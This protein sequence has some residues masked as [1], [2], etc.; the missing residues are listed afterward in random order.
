VTGSRARAAIPALVAHA[1]FA[2]VFALLLAAIGQPIFT[3]DAW[4]HLGLGEAFAAKGPWLDVDPLLFTAPRPPD[5]AAW[6]FDVALFR[7]WEAA[8]YTGLRLIH[9]AAVAAIV[10]LAWAMLRRA[11]GSG[12]A[13]SA[14][15]CAFVALSALRLVQLRPEL[16]TIFGTLALYAGL[17]AAPT[18]PPLAR[19]AVAAV[20]LCL[21]ANVHAG[22]TL[23]LLLLAV[24]SA[25]LYLAA[26]FT[27]APLR[28]ATRVRASRLAWALVLGGALTLLNPEGFHAHVA[29]FE[30]GGDTPE[31]SRVADEWV[32]WQPLRRPVAGLPPSPLAFALAW[33]LL[34]ATP[35]AIGAARRRMRARGGGESGDAA[36]ATWSLACLVAPLVAVRFLWLGF[37]PLLLLARLSATL[38]LARRAQGAALLA[39]LLVPAFVR[40]GDWPS[41]SGVM[42]R[43]WAGY[44][45]PFAAAKYFAHPFGFLDDAGL[46]GNVFTDY[47]LGG[48]AGFFGA[49]ERRA[50]INGS[51]NVSR[52][53]I[54]ANLPIRERRGARPGESFEAL[55]DRMQIDLFVGTRLPLAPPSARPWFYTTAHLEGADG[56]LCVFR[57]VD[58]AVY[59]RRNARNAANL[60]RVAAHY[61]RERV[62]FDPARGCEPDRVIRD[63]RGWA[64]SHG[65]V[66][67]HFEPLLAASRGGAPDLRRGASAQLASL[68]AALGLYERALEQDAR[69]L[70][71]DPEDAAARR[72]LVWALMRLRRFDE[73]LRAV[74]SAPPST[75]SDPLFPALADTARAAT[76][77]DADREEIASRVARLPVL[78]PADASALMAGIVGPAARTE[79]RR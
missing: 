31:L 60:E 49:P 68:Y 44:A 45:Q 69:A 3:D 62:P 65:V 6:L 32:R 70:R 50:F 58:S 33:T 4:W 24:A 40:F 48:F 38:P 23:G 29:F 52:D 34:V 66:P 1:A 16:V 61:A 14:G 57:N 36:L 35:V 28:E 41:I 5:P 17:V 47:P 78:L 77:S 59:L 13:A 43:T 46:A 76:A 9:V 20:G 37:F 75:A 26:A 53:A 27:E 72:R 63:A 30:A 73:A 25:A 71:E 7:G 51:L 74:E 15:A 42:P 54:E 2:A 39:A 56:W 64:T 22:F 55:L 67:V 79:E 12:A 18:V 21:W 10:A 8:G 11:S 19:V